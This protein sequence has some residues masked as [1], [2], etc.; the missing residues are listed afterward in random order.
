MKS[1]GLEGLSAM[2]VRQHEVMAAIAKEKSG[3]RPYLDQWEGLKPETRAQFRAGRA[4]EIL[5]ALEVVAQGIQARHA[6]MFGADEAAAASAPAASQPGQPSGDAAG[7]AAA[8]TPDL[9]QMINIYR[10]MQ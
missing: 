3:L 9:S 1:Q 8:E 6:E 4:G 5:S 10:A 2:L 7:K